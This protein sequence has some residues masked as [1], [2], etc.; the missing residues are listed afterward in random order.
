[1]FHVKRP[2]SVL[3]WNRVLVT[4]IEEPL[5][6]VRPWASFHVEHSPRRP[7]RRFHVEHRDADPERNPHPAFGRPLPRTGAVKSPYPRFARPLPPKRE[8]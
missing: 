7:T 6:V 3:G 1:M 2:S 4:M 5:G 8:R